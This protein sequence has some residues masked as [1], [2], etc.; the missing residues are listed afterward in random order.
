MRAS[1]TCIIKLAR[2]AGSYSLLLCR[3]RAAVVHGLFVEGFRR[4]DVYYVAVDVAVGASEGFLLDVVARVREGCVETSKLY[5][6]QDFYIHHRQRMY[7]A[8]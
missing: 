4:G 7:D 8:E 3:S 6:G 2:M 1:V 5:V